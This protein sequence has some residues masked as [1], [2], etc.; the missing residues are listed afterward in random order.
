MC[1]YWPGPGGTARAPS[2]SWRRRPWRALWAAARGKR[3]YAPALA[4]A[5]L[6]GFFVLPTLG[7]VENYPR[8]HTPELAQFSA[9]ARRPRPATA[10]F[11]FADAGIGGAPGIFR[12]EALRA[13][14]VDWKGG[15]QVNYLRELGE[16]WWQRWQQAGAGQVPPGVRGEVPALPIDY[17]VLRSEEP[18]AGACSRFR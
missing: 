7:K 2:R 16:Q 14:Y 12:S 8:L 4:A 18:A 3:W 6:A 11:L 1:A 17:L 10:V 9:W 15:G 13:V 5:A